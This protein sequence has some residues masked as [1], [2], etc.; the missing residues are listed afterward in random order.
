MPGKS[1][2]VP[3]KKGAP[4]AVKTGWAGPPSAGANHLP[5]GRIPYL[6]G[7]A[8]GADQLADDAIVTE[9]AV[10][11]SVPTGQGDACDARTA[12]SL[13]RRVPGH[14]PEEALTK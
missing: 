8:R 7:I 3:G 5:P 10:D 9:F 13:R 1:G 6:R 11:H 4:R 12:R 14:G 2:P